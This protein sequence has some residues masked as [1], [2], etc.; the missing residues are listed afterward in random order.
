M[1]L[2]ISHLLIEKTTKW[3]LFGKGERDDIGRLKTC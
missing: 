2:E 1:K 3:L